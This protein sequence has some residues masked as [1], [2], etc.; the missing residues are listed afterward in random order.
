MLNVAK[1]V[2]A[3]QRMTVRERRLRYAEV[4]KE[5]TKG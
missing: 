3:L 4:F 1:E 2:T 5:E